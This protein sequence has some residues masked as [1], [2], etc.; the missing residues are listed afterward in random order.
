MLH[1]RII[2]P[3][4]LTATV[5]Q[6]L[7]DDPG[8][9]HVAADRRRRISGFT[10]ARTT[11]HDTRSPGGSVAAPRSAAMWVTPGSSASSCSTV[12]VRSGGVMMRRWSMRSSRSSSTIHTIKTQQPRPCI[13]PIG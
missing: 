13:T 2:T 6:A 3:P 9:T 4:D 10:D 7:A 5:L 1:L 11:S 8:V 12:A